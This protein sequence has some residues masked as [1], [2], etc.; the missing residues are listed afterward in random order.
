MRVFPAIGIVLMCAV[1]GW[2]QLD[3]MALKTLQGHDLERNQG[4]GHPQMTRA[5]WAGARA[6][7]SRTTPTCGRSPATPTG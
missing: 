3:I 6:R 4:I 2:A 5:H 1:A 7:S